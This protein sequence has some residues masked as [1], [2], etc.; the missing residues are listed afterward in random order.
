MAVNEYALGS[1]MH[2][3]QRRVG[4]SLLC[5]AT[6]VGERLYARGPFAVGA[7]NEHVNARK[8]CFCANLR[9]MKE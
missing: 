9:I 5:A 6:G 2:L 8:G 1:E 3:A 4:G 7:G